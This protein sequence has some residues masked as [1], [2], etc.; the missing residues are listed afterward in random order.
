MKKKEIKTGSGS[1]RDKLPSKRVLFTPNHPAD[2]VL[3]VIFSDI[4]V[5]KHVV[6]MYQT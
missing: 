5:S 4:P 3:W 6:N 1:L 2:V